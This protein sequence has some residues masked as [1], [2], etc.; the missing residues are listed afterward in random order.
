MNRITKILSILL[1]SSCTAGHIVTTNLH[2]LANFEENSQIYTLPKTQVLVTLTVDK[3]EFI[4]GPYHQYAQKYL[5]ITGVGLVSSHFY[6]I[7][8]IQIHARSV[9]DPDYCF[10]LRNENFGE[11]ET[12]LSELRAKGLIME[13]NPLNYY[14][15]RFEVEG[16]QDECTD[17]TI[18]PFSFD[19]NL[20]GRSDNADA[21]EYSN[22]PLLKKQVAL[23]TMEQKAEEA[24]NF[25]FKIRKRRFLLLS[26][27][28]EVIPH[29]AA[30]ETSVQELNNL[31]QE[32]LSLF[33][34]KK[35][36]TSI[37]R[38]YSIIPSDNEKMQQFT[39]LRF[40]D[41]TGFHAAGDKVGEAIVLQLT[42]LE[43]NKTLSQLQNMGS[44][45]QNYNVLH[46]RLA[47]LANA[48]IF[49]GSHEVLEAEIPVYQ[50][51]VLLPKY[52]S[53]VKKKLF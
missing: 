38:T 44:T 12:L 30:L 33:I 13:E 48:K 7:T 24:A 37:S 53:P 51:G 6:S 45:I 3:T 19:E 28:Y 50:F 43:T 39:L 23:K 10:S 35:K 27:K 9:S 8:D 4:L 52:I 26:G 41:E 40:S 20:I 16:Q 42:D 31:E 11:V 5:D 32:Y 17:L 29:G 46:Y 22:I 36:T 21:L 34:G 18:K 15:Q 2:N 1:L 25:L 14:E 49:Y 47:D